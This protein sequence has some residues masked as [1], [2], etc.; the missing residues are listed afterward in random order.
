MFAVDDELAEHWVLAAKSLGRRVPEEMAIVTFDAPPAILIDK[1]LAIA[2]QDQ[3]G[4]AEKAARLLTQQMAHHQDD[5]L[6]SVLLPAEILVN[7]AFSE[8]R[9]VM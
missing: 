3:R 2:V 9:R 4:M 8:T 1:A 6:E 7:A 5:S